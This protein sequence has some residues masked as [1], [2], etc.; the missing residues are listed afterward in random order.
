MLKKDAE[1]VIGKL[2]YIG[3]PAV[4]LL[5]TGFA[6][7]DPVNVPKMFLLSGIAFAALFLLIQSGA[8]SLWKNNKYLLTLCLLFL[9]A[10]AIS[11]FVS[12]APWTQNFYGTFGRNTGFLTYV[13]LSFLLLAAAS[14]KKVDTYD[15]LVLA[16]L[17]AGIT[18]VFLCSLE[19]LGINIFGFNNIYGNILGT[20]GNPNFISSFLGMFIATYLAYIFK[21]ASPVIARLAAL[22]LLA[23]AFYE[24][25]D[26]KSIQGLF[27]TGIGSALVGFFVVREHLKKAY[28]QITYLVLVSISGSAAV[29]GA[30]QIGPLTKYIYK[31]SIS[32]RGEYW[33]AGLTM[34]NGHLFGGVGFDTYGDWYRRARSASAM[35]LPGATTVSNSAHNVNIELFASAGLTLIVPYLLINFYAAYLAI[36]TVL[37][38]KHYNGTY[39]AL[40]TAWICYQAQA[41][42]SINQIGIAIWGWVLTGALIGY[43]KMHKN[44]EEIKI[45]S[46]K[47]TSGKNV[48]SASIS[49]ITA[50]GL[51]TGLAIAFP[52]YYADV[53]WR[54]AL[55][56]SSIETVLAAAKRWPLDSYRISNA[57]L[58]F[59]QNKFPQQAYEMGKLGIKHNPYYFDAWK[60]MNVLSLST[61]KE[62]TVATAKMHE[63]DP[64]NLKLE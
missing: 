39:Y 27:V 9:L 37:K 57:A 31:A 2:L 33:A 4:T 6:N 45:N 5:V 13:S 44:S 46:I 19:L 50:L 35:I 58:L 25:V 22:P 40:V 49:L 8:L 20:F 61:P 36:K 7:Y 16:L 17:F 23:L 53:S 41:L 43:S 3:V 48:E 64:R 1:L 30:L 56:S 38:M 47:K 62:K 54:S 32:L 52:S 12:Q 59:E 21:P 28:F 51:A 34:G 63:L 11:L 10:G 24:I 29:L 60:V 26:S 55:R 15:K 42:I 14:V 18:N